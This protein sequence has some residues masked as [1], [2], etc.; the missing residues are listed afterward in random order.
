M[1]SLSQGSQ[2]TRIVHYQPWPRMGK[3]DWRGIAEWHAFDTITSTNSAL[4]NFTRLVS[5]PLLTSAFYLTP[6]FFNSSSPFFRI[7]SPLGETPN[8][9]FRQRRIPSAARRHRNG[10]QVKHRWRQ[11]NDI[12]A[13]PENQRK[14]LW[15][16]DIKAAKTRH[17]KDSEDQWTRS[18]KTCQQANIQQK[19]IHQTFNDA[20][21]SNQSE[22]QQKCCRGIWSKWNR[23]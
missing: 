21:D 15:A 17:S 9:L 20:N 3:W 8:Q 18:I 11:E 10:E 4:L 7:Y 14:P 6:H 23:V 5:F 22:R 13:R 19:Q 16:R 12:S 2:R 1:Q